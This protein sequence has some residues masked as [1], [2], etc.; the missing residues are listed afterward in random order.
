MKLAILTLGIAILSG[1]TIVGCSSSQNSATATTKPAPPATTVAPKPATPVQPAS[2]TTAPTPVDD[3]PRISLADAKKAFDDR[4]A[5]FV[6]THSKQT[7]DADHIAGAIN[8][9]T[10]EIGMAADKLPKGKKIIAYCS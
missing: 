10:A 5:I 7:Y 8:M 2:P 1:L 6:D 9:T 3:A 4:S